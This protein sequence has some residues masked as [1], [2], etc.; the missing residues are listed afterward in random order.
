MFWQIKGTRTTINQ[1]K[2]QEQQSINQRHKIS[3]A[4]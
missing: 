3:N 4:K 1:S 2:A